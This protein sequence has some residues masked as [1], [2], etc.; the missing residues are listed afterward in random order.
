MAHALTID[1][2]ANALSQYC[3]LHSAQTTKALKQSL[4][5]E[6]MLPMVSCDHAYQGHD[7]KG[8]R[9][10]QPYQKPYTPNNTEEHYG[11]LNTLEI[12]KV[13]LSFDW[14]EMMKF[15]DKWMCNW[16]EAGKSEQDWTYPRYIMEQLVVPQLVEDLNLSSWNGVQAAPTP[17]TAGQYLETFTG[18][19][20]HIEDFITAGK[21]TPKTI[22]VIAPTTAVDQFR[23]FCESVRADN[24]QYVNRPGKIYCSK[25]IARMY[26]FDY[27]A[28]NP[29]YIRNIT[30]P[31]Q[32][33]DRVDTYNKQVVGLESMEGSDRMIMVFDNMDSMIVGTRR[34]FPSMPQFRVHTDVREIKI[35]GEFY[36]F[37]GFESLQHIFV[38]DG[39]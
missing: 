6:T 23:Q 35:V 30:N 27:Q 16:F 15:W 19:K 13:D 12:G 32:L 34:G 33:H 24:E 29:R 37:F 26:S 22:G 21:L 5:F 9:I 36:R 14:D 10:L 8:G 7:L 25:S 1:S 4:E 3:V 17:G 39:I 28:K 2:I 20:K 31:E 11:E 18:F 38:T